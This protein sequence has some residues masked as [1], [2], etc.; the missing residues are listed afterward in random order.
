MNLYTRTKKEDIPRK[1]AS[2]NSFSDLEG[3]LSDVSVIN[4]NDLLSITLK[5]QHKT[6]LARVIFI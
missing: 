5:M 2:M 3:E 6:T 1:V 4:L